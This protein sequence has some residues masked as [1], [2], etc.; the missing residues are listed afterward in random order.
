MRDDIR[1][2]GRLL[3]HER[4]PGRMSPEPARDGHD[5]SLT[6]EPA[7]TFWADGLQGACERL[8]AGDGLYRVLS[9]FSG[10]E[11]RD[12]RLPRP[13]RL[14]SPGFLRRHRASLLVVAIYA[15]RAIVPGYLSPPS[16]PA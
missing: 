7:T 14:T 13:A 1:M 16:G 9:R 12:C 10:D 15:L 8:S 3:R 5:P 6:V 2:Q 11:A 4:R